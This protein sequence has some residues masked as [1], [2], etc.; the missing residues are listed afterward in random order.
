MIPE[1][2]KLAQST[3]KGRLIAPYQNRGV[4]WMLGRELSPGSVK[5]GMLCDEM[6]LGKT[7]QTV[8]TMLGNPVN[9]TLIVTPRSVNTQWIQEISRF[10]PKLSVGVWDSDKADISKY[11]VVLTTYGMLVNRKKFDDMTYVHRFHWDRIILDEGHEI[12]NRRSKTHQSVMTLRGTIRW[13]L[14]GTPV[15]NSMMDF[16]ALSSFLGIPGKFV[17][18]DPTKIRHSYILRRTKGDVAEHNPRLKLPPCVFEN[19]EL[20]MYPEEFDMYRSA[21]MEAREY[22]KSAMKSENVAAH[23]MNILEHLLRVRQVM[24]HPSIYVQG[25][26]TKGEDEIEE[27]SGRSRKLEYLNAS[28]REHPKEKTLIFCQFRREM[29]LI[30]EMFSD[31][32]KVFMLDGSI[33]GSMRD[34]LIAQ[35]KN[36]EGGC[37][38][39]IQ[40]KAGGVGLNLQC[41]TRVYLTAPSWNPATELQAIGRSHR[42]GQTQRVYVKKLVY[43]LDEETPSVEESMVQLQSSK[44]K[45]TAEV[46][47]DPRI[48]KDIPVSNKKDISIREI[49][50][51]FAKE[52]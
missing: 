17:Q 22:V 51:L 30:S 7:A 52:I 2:Y 21:Y 31:Y 42:T 20:N 5:G 33:T 35:F 41:A 9:R 48:E 34:S 4:L 19:V 49:R 14:S 13:I 23:T 44:S 32:Q 28:V 12:R 37:I 27:Y 36:Y 45:I 40:V 26:N 25:V 6:G 16:V 3:F 47:N 29:A 50:K 39:V 43:S 10:A 11:S 38:F 8:A 18:A 24:I 1:A 46:L 15:F